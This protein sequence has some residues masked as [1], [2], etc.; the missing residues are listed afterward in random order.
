MSYFLAKA[1]KTLYILLFL[2][3]YN[4]PLVY[5]ADD[6]ISSCGESIGQACG[7]L[8]L[9]IIILTILGIALCVWVYRDAQSRG[10]NGAVLWMLLVWFTSVIGL[11]IYLLSRPQGEMV[12]CPHCGNN[13]LDVSLICPHCGYRS[14]NQFRHR[15]ERPIFMGSEST[16]KEAVYTLCPKCGR[17]IMG[18]SKF[19]RYCGGSIE[20][21][22]KDETPFKD[23]SITC[24][25]CG[26]EI[27]DGSRFCRNCGNSI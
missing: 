15:D 21:D 14:E 17:E 2:V 7:T 20:R 1:K 22:A 4:V 16:R 6:P 10:M 19:C 13:R 27:K 5:A 8:F 18:N 25:K 24:N 11:I 23:G 9:I 3:F 26:K 12:Q